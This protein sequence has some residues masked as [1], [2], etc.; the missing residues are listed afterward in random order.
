[1]DIGEKLSRSVD[2]SARITHVLQNRV[3]TATERFGERVQK[4]AQ[5]LQPTPAA[6]WAWPQY[7]IDCAQRWVIFWDTLRQ[8]GN[9]YVEHVQQGQPPVLRFGYEIVL[10]GR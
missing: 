6:W 2:I 3:Q 5:R 8:R 10:D 9:N 4:A 7:A 1:M